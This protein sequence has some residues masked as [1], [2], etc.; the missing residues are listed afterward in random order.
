MYMSLKRREIIDYEDFTKKNNLFKFHKNIFENKKFK[1]DKNFDIDKIWTSK[2]VQMREKWIKLISKYED[3]NECYDNSKDKLNENSKRN[4][5]WFERYHNLF[6]SIKKEGYKVE[7]VKSKS[8]YPSCLAFPDNTFYRLDGTHRCS[9]MKYLGFESIT[10]KVYHFEDIINDIPELYNCYKDYI[11]INNPGY[12]SKKH[13]E[14]RK[15]TNLVEKCKKYINNK[16][17]ADIGCNAGYFTQL[18]GKTNSN[19][20]T[21]IDVS[22]NNLQYCKLFNKNKSKVDFFLGC[23]SEFNNLNNFDVFFFLRSIYHVGITIEEIINKLDSGKIFIIE[24][25][26]SHAKKFKNPEVIYNGNEK[27]WSYK[28][29]TLGHNVKAFL[30]NRGFEILETFTNYDECVIARKK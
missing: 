8:E 19:H 1:I 30:E 9:V 11:L 7:L 3:F 29:L 18:L 21:G 12:Q 22:E 5:K 14:L 20:V 24:C 28:R 6:Y 16:N 13:I 27:D 25:N 15:Y 26:S 2:N 10:V 23:I 17:V 4:K